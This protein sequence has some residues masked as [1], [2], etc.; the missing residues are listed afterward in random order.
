MIIKTTIISIYLIL[1]TYG[2]GFIGWDIL[3]SRNLTYYSLL[4]GAPLFIYNVFCKKISKKDFSL[5]AIY[6]ALMPIVSCFSKQ[7]LLEESAF[8][9]SAPLLLSLAFMFF[10]TLKYFD[11]QEDNIIKAILTIG[12]LTAIIQI[13]QQIFPNSIYFDAF[14]SEYYHISEIEI[15]NNFSRYLVG[16]SAIQL[17]CLYIMWSKAIEK[18]SFINAALTCLFL[19]SIYLYLTRLVLVATVVTI[20]ISSFFSQGKGAKRFSFIL[21]CCFIF[22]ITFYWDRL[23]GDFV[24]MSQ[25]NTY[26]TDIRWKCMSFFIERIISNPLGFIFGYG[27]SHYEEIWYREGFYASD[28]GLIGDMYHFGISWII[29]YFLF[30]FKIVIK[31][32]KTVPLYIRLYLIGT[33]ISSPFAFPYHLLDSAVVWLFIIFISDKYIIRSPKK[34]RQ[35][36]KYL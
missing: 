25:Q 6:L 9:V 5:L 4:L 31:H 22:G 10:F 17:F 35:K 12:T 15:R 36:A 11:V 13:Y 32:K 33:L 26:G 24:L 27:E 29:I 20:I 16:S 18:F 28:I 21:T 3:V 8:S 19:V 1:V 23:F 7:I 14:Q 34:H 30:V 2:L